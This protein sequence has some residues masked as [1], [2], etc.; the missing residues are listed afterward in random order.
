MMNRSAF[1][2]SITRGYQR[3]P[4]FEDRGSSLAAMGRNG[5]SVL[6]HVTPDEA[7]MLKQHGGSGTSNPRTG[8]P[9]FFPSGAGLGVDRDHSTGKSFGGSSIGSSLGGVSRSSSPANSRSGRGSDHARNTSRNNPEM[10]GSDQRSRDNL[11]NTTY[12]DAP[13]DRGVDASF[14]GFAVKSYRDRVTGKPYGQASYN[15][16]GTGATL[17]KAALGPLGMVAAPA[18]DWAADRFGT[19]HDLGRVSYQ[20]DAPAQA[21]AQDSGDPVRMGQD[22]L[23]SVLGTGSAT[24]A[25]QAVSASPARSYQ[26]FAGDHTRYAQPGQGGEHTFFLG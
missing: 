8:L 5:D 12:G 18:L 14:G 1:G 9:E 17:G 2:P 13:L 25:Q 7:Q 15:A 16:L 11:D 24:P 20:P 6:A 10:G 3:T 19:K 23:R 21:A 22:L 4:G 26:P